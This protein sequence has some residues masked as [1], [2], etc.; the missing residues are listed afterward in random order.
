MGATGA[1]GAM[2][3]T[4]ATGPGGGTVL[5]NFEENPTEC[6]NLT[7]KYSVGNDL[8]GNGSLEAGE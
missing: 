2:G 4:G 5:L 3:A 8:N 7:T 6:W 1:A